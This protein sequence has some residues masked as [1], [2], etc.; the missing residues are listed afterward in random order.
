[1][2]PGQGAD[3][4]QREHTRKARRRVD[5]RWPH[6]EAPPQRHPQADHEEESEE[7][8]YRLVEEIEV[9]LQELVAEERQRDVPV[10]RGEDRAHEERQ[11]APEH[12]RVHDAR[13]RLRQR[14]HL[15]ERVRGDEAEA[16]GDPV[17]T[18]LGHSL[19]PEH[20]QLVETINEIC[21]RERAADVEGDL[22]PAR[23]V[24]ERIAEWNGRGHGRNL[25][26]RPTKPGESA[27]PALSPV[28]WI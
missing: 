25:S 11:E 21:D 3:K 9:A 8:E 7:V 24:P 1:R 19:S 6:D 16:L 18:I 20:H 28:S 2:D 12:D 5:A 13:I 10:D 15:A 14:T 27:R 4:E 22:R 23:D 26:T 17:E